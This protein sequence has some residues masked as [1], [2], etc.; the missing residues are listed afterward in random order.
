MAT[1]VDKKN[2]IRQGITEAEIVYFQNLAGK[3]LQNIYGAVA[4]EL[5]ISKSP[6]V[7]KCNRQL[8]LTAMEFAKYVRDYSEEGK[9]TL[10][11]IVMN[12]AGNEDEKALI[13][14]TFKKN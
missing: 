6:V 2:A 5:N 1:K 14:K 8:G 12:A 7:D 10:Y 13:R 11:D 3:T 4:S 9:D